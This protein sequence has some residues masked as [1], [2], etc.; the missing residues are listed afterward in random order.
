MNELNNIFSNYIDQG[1]YPGIQWQI[2]INNETFSGK[3]GFNNIKDKTPIKENTIY[4]IWSMTKPIVAVAAMQLIEEKKINFNDPITKFLPEF[5]NLKVLK[6]QKGNIDDIEDVVIFPT[7][8]D[9][10]LHTAGFSYNFLSDPVG[11]QY[12][13]TKLFNSD[14]TSLEDE[15]KILSNSPLLFQPRTA[16]RYSVSMDVLARILEVVENNS[17]ANIL[18]EKIFIPLKMFET[19]F[20][21]PIEESNRLMQ[22]YEYDPINSKLTEL[23]TDPQRIG[24]YGYPINKKN[25]ARGGHGLFSTIKDYSIFAKMLHDGKSEEGKTIIKENSLKL[26][27]TNALES[28]YFPIEIASIGIEQNEN[29]TNDLEAYGW[30]FGF[31]TLMNPIKNNNLGSVGEFGWAGAAST[32]FL[33]DNEKK[34]TA[35]LMTQVLSG[36]PNLKKDFYKFIYSNF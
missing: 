36:N 9:L 7:I 24:N 19:D 22:S 12:D 11:K 14:F 20:S 6:N 26:M 2:N 5:S 18:K 35:L 17:L 31:R 4:R 23:I 25:Y 27:R 28:K 3:V 30:G 32:Y 34:M 8:S 29:Y 16:W 15:I 1:F 21:I 33:V 10:L 13:L